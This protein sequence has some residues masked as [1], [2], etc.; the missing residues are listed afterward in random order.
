MADKLAELVAACEGLEDKRAVELADAFWGPVRAGLRDPG[1]GGRVASLAASGRAR[2]LVPRRYVRVADGLARTDLDRPGLGPA[3]P[4]H[5]YNDG[6]DSAA[7]LSA[8]AGRLSRAP[9]RSARLRSPASAGTFILTAGAGAKPRH[10]PP[11]P[12]PGALLVTL[13]HGHEKARAD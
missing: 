4:G 1:C 13:S 5:L 11:S 12:P 10:D 6:R 2:R 3:P 8:S 7:V 9:T